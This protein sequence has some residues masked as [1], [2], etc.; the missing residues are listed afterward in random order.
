MSVIYIK[1]LVVEAKHGVHQDEK[2]H[3]QR[4]GVNVELTIDTAK[5]G[6]SDNLDDT[7]NWSDLRAAI[8]DT[9][10]NSSFNLVERLVQEVAERI[11]QDKRVQRLVLSIDK[12]DAFKTGVP[13]V[14]LEAKAPL[15]G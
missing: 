1:D 10:Q 7:I 5:A 15:N 14:R 9:I 12:L 6:L 8:I 2:D 11:L 13:G 4:F 3:A